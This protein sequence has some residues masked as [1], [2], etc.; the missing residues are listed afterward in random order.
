MVKKNRLTVQLQVRLTEEM[1]AYLD[2]QAAKHGTDRAGDVRSLLSEGGLP[3]VRDDAVSLL[4][5]ILKV[6]QKRYK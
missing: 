2:E 4:R 3:Q 1:S 6:L 5:E